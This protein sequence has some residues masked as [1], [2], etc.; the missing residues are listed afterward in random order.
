M[1]YTYCKDDLMAY[2]LSEEGNSRERPEVM[3]YSGGPISLDPFKIFKI[4]DKLK[5]N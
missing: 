2:F 5:I 1:G 3:C 4:S